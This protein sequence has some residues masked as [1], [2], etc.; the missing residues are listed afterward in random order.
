MLD[1][2]VLVRETSGGKGGNGILTARERTVCVQNKPVTHVR[3]HD[4]LYTQTE[5]PSRE[6]HDE[7]CPG[8]FH[9]PPGNFE[10][11]LFR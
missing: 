1:K 4:Q 6:V 2:G 7:Q 8:K 9:H 11:L 10:G 5:T 3:V